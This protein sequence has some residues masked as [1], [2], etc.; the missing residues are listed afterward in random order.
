[1][2]DKLSNTSLKSKIAL[3]YFLILL[4]SGVAIFFLY[5][6]IQNLQ[7]LDKNNTKP[8]TKLFKINQILTL[9]YE[10]EN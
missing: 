8:N 6:G 9:I 3:S 2:K 7:L 4:A 1:M 10:A 5:T